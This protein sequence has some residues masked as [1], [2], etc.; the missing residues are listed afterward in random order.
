M[1]GPGLLSARGAEFQAIEQVLI[2]ACEMVT[3][4]EGP[5][6]R[7]TFRETLYNLAL[8]AK[9]SDWDFSPVSAVRRGAAPSVLSNQEN[10]SHSVVFWL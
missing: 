4:R 9:A 2:G 6:H 8:R 3:V 7:G 1:A 5:L 10:F